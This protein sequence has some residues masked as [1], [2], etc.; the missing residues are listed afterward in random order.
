MVRGL[1]RDSMEKTH[2]ILLFKLEKRCYLH[3]NNKIREVKQP[4][5]VRRYL[6][7][8]IDSRY[9]TTDIDSRYFTNRQP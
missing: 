5:S 3:T 6:T 7:T 4:K 9:F 1:H 2:W 8:D